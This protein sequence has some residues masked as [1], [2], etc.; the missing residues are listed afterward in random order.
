M[1]ARMR[2]FVM[3]TFD[4]QLS[5]LLKSGLIAVGS[6]GN[7]IH[8]ARMISLLEAVGCTYKLAIISI[9]K[10]LLPLHLDLTWT[11]ADL[12]STGLVLINFS[13]TLIER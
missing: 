10:N 4:N 8:Q 11:N 1:E 2:R 12:L 6:Y 13:A 5:V 3:N 7:N 9:I